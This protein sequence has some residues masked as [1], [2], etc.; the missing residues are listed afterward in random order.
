MSPAAGN[1]EA[2]EEEI[3]PGEIHGIF[4][5]GLLEPDDIEIARNL[6]KVDNDNAGNTPQ[7]REG[8]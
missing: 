3:V 4:E 1:V 2:E 7:A 6:V 8:E 5:H